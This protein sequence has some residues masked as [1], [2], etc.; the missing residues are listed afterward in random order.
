MIFNKK[1]FAEL[2]NKAKGDDRSINQY[3]HTVG[4]SPA[5]ISRLLRE[6]LDTP[7][8]PETIYKLVR[9]ARNDITY[10]DL[11]YAAGYLDNT[12]STTIENSLCDKY[13]FLDAKTDNIIQIK[14]KMFQ[15]ITSELYK[16]NSIWSISKSPNDLYDI[17]VEKNNNKYT[18]CYVKFATNLDINKLF[19][20]YGKISTIEF[21]STIKY[22]IAVN[23]QS[24]FDLI[25]NN[26]PKALKINLY[27]LLINQSYERIEKEKLLCSY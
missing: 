11:M 10:S 2:L 26:I 15:I 17:I 25:I 8:S 27:A 14:E 6:L 7:P 5:H 3:A 9:L 20:L 13:N 4:I 16:S 19:L 1:K 21:S 22:S 24:N 23:S 18:K 12:A